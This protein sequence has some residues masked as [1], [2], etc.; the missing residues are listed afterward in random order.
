MNNSPVPPFLWDRPPQAPVTSING[1]T[2]IG[3]NLNHI[4]RHGETGEQHLI[5]P[6]HA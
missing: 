3:G 6:R 2:F 5:V 1:G 4:Q